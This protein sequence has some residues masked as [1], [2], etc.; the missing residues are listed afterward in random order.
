MDKNYESI[1]H[2][3]EERNWWFKGRRDAVKDMIRRYNIPKDARIIDIGCAGGALLVELKELG[4]ENLY[5]LDYSAEAIELCKKRGIEHA[6]Q[7]D[8]H[9]PQFPEGTFD[10]I[11]A[12]D[13][14]EHLEDDN[15]ALKNWYKILKAGGKVFIYVPAYEFLWSEHDEVNFHY[16]R[17]TRTNLSAKVK[18]NGF[19]IIKA[20]YWNNL[21]LLPTMTV[22]LL[23]K[24]KPKRKKE[25]MKSDLLQLSDPVNNMLTSWLKL[26][27]SMNKV[28]HLPFG[29]S[30][31]V[32]V[33][34]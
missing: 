13:S 19:K 18:A 21:I 12:S 31:Y 17:Y 22:R 1:Y 2:D 9:D 30:T 3:E 11:I 6:Y 7:M 25:E 4:Y 10:L 5:A 26:E 24:L 8:G 32:I 29:V 27:N 33:S 16:R 23:S 20:G 28:L 14:L 34:K 15:K